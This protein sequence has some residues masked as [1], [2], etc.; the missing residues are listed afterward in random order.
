MAFPRTYKD[1][2][3]P[4]FIYLVIALFFVVVAIVQNMNSTHTYTIGNY[5]THTS[6]LLMIFVMKIVYILFWTWILNLICRDGHKE[7]AWILVFLPFI[8]L[9]LLFFSVIVR[10]GFQEGIGKKSSSTSSGSSKPPLAAMLAH[11]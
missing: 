3:T 10:E 2:C 7:I 11:K 6:S 5:T 8:L 9:F 1:L 4:A